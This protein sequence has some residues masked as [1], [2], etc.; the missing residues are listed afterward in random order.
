[1]KF[2]ICLVQP[3]NFVHIYAYWELAELLHFSL[4]ELGH[5]SSLQLKKMEKDAINIIFGCHLLEIDLIPKIPKSTIFINTEQIYDNNN[6]WSNNILEWS[7]HFEMWDYSER[8]IIRFNE[9]GNSSVKLL[10]LG[11]QK[12]LH[13]I[14]RLNDLDIDVLFYGSLNPRRQKILDELKVRGLNVISV[15]GLYGNK[16]DELVARSK[17]VLNL[18]FYKSEIFEVVRV[19]Y[20]LNNA[21]A[22]VGEVNQS[23]SIQKMYAEAI[24]AAP[25]EEL[26]DSCSKLIENRAYRNEIAMK[27]F[28]EIKKFPQIYFTDALLTSLL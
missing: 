18:H 2:N 27:G 25:Y 24:V 11:Y 1:M 15:Y 3:S 21:I 26:A 28:E 19:F 7:K 17:L 5:E 10:Q 9:A 6:E 23:T 12:E 20:L 22:V 16:R 13:R 14:K 8:N 4:I